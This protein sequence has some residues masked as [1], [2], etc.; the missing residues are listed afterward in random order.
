MAADNIPQELKFEELP[1]LTSV[2]DKLNK[3]KYPKHLL[4]G[5]GFS[6]AYDPKIFSYNAL[7]DFIENQEDPTLIRLFQVI[8]TKNFELVMRQLDNFIEIARAFDEEGKLVE[9]LTNANQLLQKSLIEAVSSLHP[10]H[11]F[12]VSEG[13]SKA[14]FNFLEEFLLNDGNVYSTNYDLL[15]YWVL[16][17]NES[18]HAN[19]GFGREHLNPVETRKGI[20]DAAY[21]E[22]YWGKHKEQQ[23]VFHLHGTLPIFDTGT[24]IEKEVYRDR[25]YLLQNIKDRMDSKEYPIFVTAGDGTEKLRHIFHNRYLTYCYDSLC[26]INGFLVTFGFNFGEYDYHIIEAV[27]RSAKRGAQS[28]EKLFSIYI[29]V[30][31]EDDLEYIKSI[32]DKFDCKVNVYN[33][34][35]ANIWSI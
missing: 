5:N 15:L 17:R 14:C 22:L 13:R 1:D 30:Y 35:T 9:A 8:N 19:D 28:G 32:Q 7:Y 33:S 12:E 34:R 29:G 24:E 10:E 6:M 4:I 21:G 23:K 20:E 27:N 26:N 25:Q 11:V 2:I 18:K 31:S 16:M 3:R